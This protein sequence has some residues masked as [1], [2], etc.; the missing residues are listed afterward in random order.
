VPPALSRIEDLQNVVQAKQRA[1]DAAKREF[2]ACK[3]VYIW[4][5][6]EAS[7]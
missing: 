6:I 5:Y 1:V 3:H 7:G 2:E 4:N